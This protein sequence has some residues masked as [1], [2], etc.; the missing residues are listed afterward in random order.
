MRAQLQARIFMG[1][2]SI[3]AEEKINQPKNINYNQIKLLLELY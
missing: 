2:C 1:K 3:T